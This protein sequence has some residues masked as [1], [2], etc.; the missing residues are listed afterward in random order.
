MRL[1]LQYRIIFDTRCINVAL[2]DKN[3]NF[4]SKHLL[5][6]QSADIKFVRLVIVLWFT[7]V[8]LLEILGSILFIDHFETEIRARKHKFMLLIML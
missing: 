5:R 8:P 3:R 2:I 6:C 4:R 7:L 1:I